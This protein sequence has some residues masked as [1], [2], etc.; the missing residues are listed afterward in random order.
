MKSASPILID[1]SPQHRTRNRFGLWTFLLIS[2]CISLS[3]NAAAQTFGGATTMISQDYWAIR[4]SM[5][6]DSFG[7]IYIAYDVSVSRSPIGPNKVL[8]VRELRLAR[9]RDGG[10]TFDVK[11]IA[12]GQTRLPSLAVTAG[13]NIHIAYL[14]GLPCDG[15]QDCHD[16]PASERPSIM[17]TSSTDGG[18][19]FSAPVQ[20]STPNITNVDYETNIAVDGAGK[21]YVVW[22]ESD[23]TSAEADFNYSLNFVKMR[24][25]SDQ[26]RT[27][28]NHVVIHSDPGTSVGEQFFPGYLSNANIAVTPA[29]QI[30]VT[31]SECKTDFCSEYYYR[32]S[33]GGENFSSPLLID[34]QV[35]SVTFGGH[36]IAVDAAGRVSAVYVKDDSAFFSGPQ[37]NVYHARIE[38]GAVTRRT[39]VSAVP[40]EFLAYE[41]AV[42]IDALGRI[43]VAWSG[44]TP[45]APDRSGPNDIFVRRSIDGGQT[46]SAQAN[47][48]NTPAS[49][50]GGGHSYSPALAISLAGTPLITWGDNVEACDVNCFSRSGELRFRRG[51]DLVDVVDPSGADFGVDDLG[52]LLG[53]VDV[54]VSTRDDSRN[55]RGGVVA[56][57]V[58]K[59]LIMVRS[60]SSLT[61]TLR[62]ADNLPRGTLA[63]LGQADP[64]GTVA[65]IPSATASNGESLVVAVYTSPRSYGNTAGAQ[66]SV[67]LEIRPTDSPDTGSVSIALSIHRPPIM[68]IPDLWGTNRESGQSPDFV[69]FYLALDAK[70]LP[71]HGVGYSG[72]QGQTFDPAIFDPEGGAPTDA[73]YGR[74]AEVLELEYANN[75]IAASQVDVVGHGMG[76]LIARSLIQQGR[77][78]YRRNKNYSQ[79]SIHRLLT[80]GT[81]HFGS[82]LAKVLFDNRNVQIAM[83]D[84]QSKTL[85]DY[86]RELGQ[87]LDNG[88]VEA[89]SPGSAAF[90]RLTE[91]A[92]TSQALAGLW[93]D[94]LDPLNP[95]ASSSHAALESFLQIALR[96]PALS[97]DGVFGTRSHDLFAT[98]ESQRAD[99]DTNTLF[100]F[101]VVHSKLPPGSALQDTAEL[102]SEDLR[103]RVIDLLGTEDL[104][105]FKNGFPA[106]PPVVAANRASAQVAASSIKQNAPAG[107]GVI[108]ITSPATGE[109]FHHDPNTSL[110]VTAEAAGGASPQKV[111]FLVEG[112]GTFVAPSAPPY[113]VSFNVPDHA[114]LGRLAIQVLAL[115]ASGALLG[116]ST[117]V[118]LIQH[119]DAPLRQ[120]QVAPGEVF[121]KLGSAHQLLVVGDFVT[122]ANTVVPKQIT[123][124]SLGTTYSARGGNRIVT[125][126][127]DGLVTAV[128]DG[129]D[130]LEVRYRDK[131]ALVPVTVVSTA[132]PTLAPPPTSTP[133]PC[134]SYSISGRVT[135]GGGNGLGGVT[136]TLQ[137]GTQTFTTF[138]DSNGHYSFGDRPAGGAYRITASKFRFLF[139]PPRQ[140]FDILS[141]NEVAD[142]SGAPV[143]SRGG[144]NGRI[145]FS[146]SRDSVGTNINVEIYA[147]DSAGTN[148][149]RL[150]NNLA[151][152]LGPSWSPD[153]TKLAFISNRDGN[154]EVYVMNSD[155]SSPT[156]LT[157]APGRDGD[158]AWSPDGRKIAFASDREG[159]SAIYVMN[160]EGGAATRVTSDSQDD[161]GPTWSPSGGKLAFESRRDGDSEIYAIEADGTSLMKL[162]DNEARDQHPSWSPDGARIV[163]TSNQDGNEEIYLI[164]ANGGNQLRLTDNSARDLQPAWSPDGMRI[165]FDSERDGQ[166]D[167]YT[168]SSDGGN[169]IRVTDQAPFNSTA[170]WQP[171]PCPGAGGECVPAPLINSFSPPSGLP[172]SGVTISGANFAGATNLRVN[173]TEATFVVESETKISALVPI[174][175]ATGPIS[176]T[177][178]GGNAFSSSSYILL[179]DSDSDGLS[180][181]FEQQYFGSPIAGDSAG[182]SDGDGATNPEEFLAGTDPIDSASVF[183]IIEIRREGNDMTIAF[184]ARAHKRYRL[185]ASSSLADN[186]PI[187]IATISRAA[188]DQRVEI[189]DIGCAQ[190]RRFYRAVVLP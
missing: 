17:V 173:G 40:R 21:V 148:Q 165:V 182:D 161:S 103:L 63:R 117:N 47:L 79:G 116:D 123:A 152:D 160:A 76:G 128:S 162:T 109:T 4:S 170:D 136:M 35:E 30:H 57:G 177:T 140:G 62:S 20:V 100:F 65:V 49:E 33:V 95:G 133:T 111:I 6:V 42:A 186:F 176:I 22:A 27:F 87:S 175:A 179:A 48:S 28:S 97:L 158:P 44:P 150:T 72:E 108:R 184:R 3:M 102:Q 138:S 126:S 25:S 15:A 43:Y 106:A 1:S 156:R 122:S 134:G 8:E 67:T 132:A 16:R 135:D 143:N 154:F 115:D 39:N 34:H 29:G 183:R 142:F 5:A 145:A 178:P 83:P 169:I 104:Q 131:V 120:I 70:G 121:L 164:D 37:T 151:T 64:G 185:E 78:Y 54:A 166:R 167:I 71:V 93:D 113:T 82:P 155:G 125:V 112:V 89:L 91:T 12:S 32:H 77:P 9:S 153:G 60:A 23:T 105:R 69:S 168:M 174:G 2:G 88:A 11:V 81:P 13:G 55:R 159:S 18:E 59:L 189:K 190:T 74:I 92:V 163:F 119:P 10:A 90:S 68:L 187:E 84:G 171:I 110:T 61:L 172:G 129:V 114:K 130:T 141:A 85:A 127:S 147:A 180:D 41:P 107:T 124:G 99:P 94:P 19:N 137:A 56:D 86:F 14:S 80:F 101:P 73:L 181:E 188:S 24:T 52:N 38:D 51:S 149:T 96:D 157:D 26:G 45:G 146:S 46:F 36:D 31:W 118:S 50:S 7:D 53:S 58:S 98:E 139:A 144:A 66:R 75:S